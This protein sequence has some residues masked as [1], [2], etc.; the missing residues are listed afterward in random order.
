MPAAEVER[1]LVDVDTRFRAARVNGVA[2]QLRGRVAASAPRVSPSANWSKDSVM[3]GIVLVMSPASG[4]EYS[5]VMANSA[6]REPIR[7]YACEQAEW[8]AVGPDHAVW[9]LHLGDLHREGALRVDD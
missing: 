6:A 8:H 1:R 7:A 2:G 5:S 4:P 9:R 3:S